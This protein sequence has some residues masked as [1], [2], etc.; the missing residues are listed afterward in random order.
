MTN[1]HH[2]ILILFSLAII[3]GLSL[4]GDRSS[5]QE[6]TQ[7]PQEK[8]P[9]ARPTPTFADFVYG[10]ASER[11]RFDF[12]KAESDKPTPVVLL[13]HGGGWK[14][15]DKTGYGNNPIQ[16]YLQAGISV[17]AINYRFINEAM[18]QGVEPPVKAPL[19]DAA[20][21]LQTIRAH[22]KEWNIDPERIPTQN[23]SHA[24]IGR[25]HV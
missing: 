6:A 4:I 23:E 10:K 1:K 9:P 12:W 13:I 3:A 7:A 16:K 18:K 20:R 5:G 25:A 22:S 11:Q 21:A 15:G 17:A 14:N 24:E 8:K 19:V 2:S